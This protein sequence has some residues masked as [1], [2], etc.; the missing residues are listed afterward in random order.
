MKISNNRAFDELCRV[1]QSPLRRKGYLEL[2][3]KQFSDAI[4][5]F[6]FKLTNGFSLYD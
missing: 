1:T 6:D 4:L 5:Q 2:R 3:A